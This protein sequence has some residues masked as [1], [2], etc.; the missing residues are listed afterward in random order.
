[1]G[2]VARRC[3]RLW[4]VHLKAKGSTS[5]AKRDEPLTVFTSPKVSCA[6]Q[7]FLM[8]RAATEVKS[9]FSYGN[10]LAAERVEP[11]APRALRW[12][13]ALAYTLDV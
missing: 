3:D 4:G 1:M 8:T 11:R 2:L 13:C 7:V 12:L 10:T 9:S 6:R 5:P